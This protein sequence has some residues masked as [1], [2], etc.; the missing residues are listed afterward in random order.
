MDKE[1]RISFEC[2][3]STFMTPPLKGEELLRIAD[4]LANSQNVIHNGS[5][6]VVMDDGL[7]IRVGVIPANAL[8]K[9]DANAN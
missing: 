2:G 8:I 1:R 4:I 3:W 9:D 7:K 5:G 6:V